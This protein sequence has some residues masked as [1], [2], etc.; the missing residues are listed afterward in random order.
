M[1]RFKEITKKYERTKNTM[2]AILVQNHKK[3]SKSG[4]HSK[5]GQAAKFPRL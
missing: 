1:L 2:R 4:K 5:T 3:Q